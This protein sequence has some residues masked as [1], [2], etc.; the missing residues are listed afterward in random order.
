MTKTEFKSSEVLRAELA[1]A[2]S[3]PALKEALSVLRE[4]AIPS[5]GRMPAMVQGVHYDTTLAHQYYEFAGIQSVL[6]QLNDLTIPNGAQEA[7]DEREYEHT[8]PKN[9]QR[10]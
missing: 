8:L 7:D 2:L 5:K 4:A 3:S 9:L 1:I 6:K 10:Q